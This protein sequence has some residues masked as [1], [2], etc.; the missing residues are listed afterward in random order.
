ML[1]LATCVQVL[2][3]VPRCICKIKRYFRFPGLGS[4]A[5]DFVN[6]ILHAV[7]TPVLGP[8]QT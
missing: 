4:G 2:Y 5:P 1:V 7:E 8:R 3:Y 6:Y